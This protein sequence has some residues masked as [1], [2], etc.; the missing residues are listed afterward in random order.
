MMAIRWQWIL[1]L[2]LALFWGCDDMTI[3]V[4]TAVQSGRQALLRKDCAQALPHFESVA[5]L[6]PGYV[7]RS[8][9]F[10]AGIWSYVG[11]CQ[12]ANGALAEARQALEQALAKDQDDILAR[13]YYGAALLRG[14]DVGRGRSELGSALQS[15]HDWIENLLTSRAAE[16]YW[17]P[18]KQLRA[19]IKK[20]L[21]AHEPVR[22][23][24]GDSRQRRMARRR[25]RRGD[26][27]GAPRGE[28]A[29]RLSRF[30]RRPWKNPSRRVI[31]AAD[32]IPN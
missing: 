17:D 9:H 25:S 12:Y 11:R 32:K 29:R 16:S 1:G 14:G 18:N 24:H 4:G 31:L 6:D 5:R 7:Y 8:A 23:Q 2:M 21:G 3:R 20:T 30:S 13:L 10:H 19:E 15:L 26:R 28:P 27:A 22:R